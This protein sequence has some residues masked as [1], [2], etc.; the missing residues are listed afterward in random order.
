[1]YHTHIMNAKVSGRVP[2][3]GGAVERERGARGLGR[4]R[5]LLHAPQ[6]LL[7]DG[8][9]R[10]DLQQLLLRQLVPALRVVRLRSVRRRQ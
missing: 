5:V 9:P 10:V 1:M 8:V 4:L 6:Q 7:H 3:R 2:E